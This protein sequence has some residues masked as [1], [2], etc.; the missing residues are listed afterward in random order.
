[1]VPRFETNSSL[2]KIDITNNFI[3]GSERNQQNLSGGESK[4]I[5]GSDAVSGDYEEDIIHRLFIVR[6]FVNG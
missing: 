2:L 1:M 3:C 5:G 6:D 4:G